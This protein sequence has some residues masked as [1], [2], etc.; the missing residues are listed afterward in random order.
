MY[1]Y[2]YFT[3]HKLRLWEFKYTEQGLIASKM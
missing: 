1:Y 3:K 2:P